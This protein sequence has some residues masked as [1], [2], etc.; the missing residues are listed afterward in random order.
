LA[1]LTKITAAGTDPSTVCPATIASVQVRA[2][3]IAVGGNLC[4]AAGIANVA[5]NQQQQVISACPN[6]I[7]PAIQVR[8]T[9]QFV[10]YG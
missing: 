7:N 6:N 10:D 4:T 5:A 3:C 1:G 8:Y 9:C 2:L